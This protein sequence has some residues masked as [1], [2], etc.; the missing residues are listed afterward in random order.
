LEENN[1]VLDQDLWRGISSVLPEPFMNREDV[2][3][4]LHRGISLRSLMN[5]QAF[6]P[7]AKM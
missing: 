1:D 4:V 5:A 2:G 3:N 7:F 6:D